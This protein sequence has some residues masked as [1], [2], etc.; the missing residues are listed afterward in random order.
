MSIPTD[1]EELLS[2]VM[3]HGLP[4]PLTRKATPPQTPFKDVR[5]AHTA[6]FQP[7]LSGSEGTLILGRK[8]KKKKDD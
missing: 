7:R 2:M 3:I 1:L 5:P 6:T 8:A 4:T